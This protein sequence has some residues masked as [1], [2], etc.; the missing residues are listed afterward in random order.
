MPASIAYHTRRRQGPVGVAREQ[1]SSRAVTKLPTRPAVGKRPMSPGRPDLPTWVSRFVGAVVMPTN[2]HWA[3][4]VSASPVT[5]ALAVIGTHDGVRQGQ[6]FNSYRWWQFQYLIEVF[7]AVKMLPDPE[8]RAALADPERFVGVIERVNDQ[9]AGIQ[10]HSLEH[11]LFPDV[12]APVVSRDH[13]A[14]ILDHWK[15]LAAAAPDSPEP[16]RLSRVVTSLASNVSWDGGDYVDLY[17]SP[18]LWRWSEPTVQWLTFREWASRISRG[19]DLDRVERDYK[20]ASIERLGQ[21]AGAM[22]QDAPG[23]PKLLG[24]AFTK[25]NNLVG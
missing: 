5:A 6:A 3:Y 20:L 22:D 7:V 14:T 23:W 19:I 8:R 10:R 17:T 24:T 25:D 2:H 18:Y 9:G 11:L 13:R 21:A 15:D 4:P 16:L 12:L 1:L